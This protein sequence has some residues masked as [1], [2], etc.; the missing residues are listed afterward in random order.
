MDLPA[1]FVLKDKSIRL[2]KWW[3]D[4]VDASDLHRDANAAPVLPRIHHHFEQALQKHQPLFDELDD[5]DSNLWIL[6]PSLPARRCSVE[7]RI[8]LWEGGASMVI[9]LDPEN[10]RGIPVMVR[11]LGVTLATMKAAANAAADRHVRDACA[12]GVVDWRTS[13]AKFVSED[14]EDA[15]RNKNHKQIQ[16]DKELTNSKRWSKERSIRENLEM[17]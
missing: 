2:E 7:R 4:G 9:V 13:F 8:A 5:L 14:D 6:E 15:K 1:D 3:E 11:F 16:S 10:A 17:W 12:E